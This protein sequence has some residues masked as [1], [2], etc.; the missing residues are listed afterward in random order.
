MPLYLRLNDFRL[1]CRCQSRSTPIAWDAF[2]KV[3]VEVAFGSKRIDSIRGGQLCPGTTVNVQSKTS[4]KEGGSRTK[5]PISSSMDTC[6]P[7]YRYIKLKWCLSGK[8]QWS[9]V[10]ATIKKQKECFPFSSFA[11]ATEIKIIVVVLSFSS[12]SSS[13]LNFSISAF[14]LLL[15]LLDHQGH[16]QKY[17]NNNYRS[18]SGNGTLV[19][20]LCCRCQCRSASSAFCLYPMICISRSKLL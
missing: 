3:L 12:S 16:H 11:F 1:L 8:V 5:R 14:L 18:L 19:S 7:T 15:L 13:W 20:S 9:L 10:C 6:L 2:K 4:I 17:N